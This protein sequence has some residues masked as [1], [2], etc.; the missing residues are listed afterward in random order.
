MSILLERFRLD[1]LKAKEAV[2]LY[3]KHIEA[4]NIAEVKEK[5][6]EIR[7][8]ELHHIDELNELILKHTK[9]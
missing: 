5:L 4:I 6:M 2:E 3:S 1:L 7:K 8:E 9:K